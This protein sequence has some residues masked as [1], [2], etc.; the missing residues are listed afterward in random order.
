M[1]DTDRIESGSLLNQSIKFSDH[2]PSNLTGQSQY[3]SPPASI[4]TPNVHGGA[5]IVHLPPD[6]DKKDE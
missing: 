5:V 1:E 4:N 3:A 6:D 2:L